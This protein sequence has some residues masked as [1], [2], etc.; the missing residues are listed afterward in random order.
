MLYR[1]KQQHIHL[2]RAS[3]APPCSTPLHKSLVAPCTC[4][5]SIVKLSAWLALICPPAPRLPYASSLGIHTCPNTPT[6]SKHRTATE[7]HTPVHSRVS[8][9]TAACMR[10][11]ACVLH[12]VVTLVSLPHEQQCLR[13]SFD[14][15]RHSERGRAASVVAGVERSAVLQCAAVVNLH[16]AR[17]GGVGARAG[18]LHSV[19]QPRRQT[20][21][22]VLSSHLSQPRLAIPNTA[23][24]QQQARAVSCDSYR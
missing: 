21:H 2:S 4:S 6:Q 14:D 19:Q 22:A 3:V 5:S 1:A 9:A 24:R 18:R 15:L 17:S 16:A 12:A 8:R 13:P 20:T 10:A 7:Q 23:Q 11:C